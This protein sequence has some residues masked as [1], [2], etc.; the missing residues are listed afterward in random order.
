M[1]AFDPGA[2]LSRSYALP[3]GPRVRLRLARSADGAAIAA[4]AAE[5]G[6]DLDPLA[7]ARLLRFDR[8]RLVIC[9][10]ALI[11]AEEVFAGFGAI[12]LEPGARPGLVLVDQ[13]LTDG[14]G[15]LLAAALAGRAAAIARFRAA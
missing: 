1:T 12:D 6:V 9:A 15:E 3:R 8:R 2:L 7:L 11:G 13:E 4:L 14:L 5:H 10:M